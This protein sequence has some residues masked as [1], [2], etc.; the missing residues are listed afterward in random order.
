M[1][2][3]SPQLTIKLLGPLEVWRGSKLLTRFRADSARALLAYLAMQQGVGLRRE[4]LAGLLSPDRPEEEARGY[5]RRLLSMLRQ[6]LQ[7]AKDAPPFIEANRKT[8]ALSGD[9]HI[10]VDVAQFAQLIAAVKRHRHRQLA[11]CQPCLT[12]LE[13]ATMLVRG[14]FM[15][16]YALDNDVWEEWLATQR[17]TW[18]QTALEALVRL[19]ES[20]VEREEWQ[21]AVGV[22]R[23]ILGLEAWHE[24]AHRFVM[25]GLWRLGDRA[26]A[27]AQFEW[28]EQVLWDELGVGVEEKTERLRGEN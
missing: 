16:G 18:R 2:G 1:T 9:E 26:A 28:C 27:L 19:G 12:R 25:E 17:A 8:I 14:D 4:Q 7:E 15:A 5:L 6:G 10:V 3:N 20:R 13:Q 11:G 21:A 23:Q 22:G 24:G